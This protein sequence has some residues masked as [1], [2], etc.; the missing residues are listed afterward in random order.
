MRSYLYYLNRVLAGTA[1]LGIASQAWGQFPQQAGPLVSVPVTTNACQGVGVALSSDGRT[2]IVGA[3]GDTGGSGTTGNECN[4]GAGAAFVYLHTSS[5]WA[6]QARL[7]GTG[8]IG[9]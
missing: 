1:V 6:Q 9:S 5:G 8:A 2:A 7:V 4:G 3:P